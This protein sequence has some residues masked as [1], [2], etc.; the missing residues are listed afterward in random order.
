MFVS[1]YETLEFFYGEYHFLVEFFQSSFLEVSASLY[2]VAISATNA[3]LDLLMHLT[4][5]SLVQENL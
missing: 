3:A 4:F 1:F 2:A 5:T